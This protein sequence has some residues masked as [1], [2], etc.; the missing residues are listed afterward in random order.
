MCTKWEKRKKKPTNDKAFVKAFILFGFWDVETIGNDL[1]SL[2]ADARMM[3]SKGKERKWWRMSIRFCEHGH[4][5]SHNFYFFSFFSFFFSTLPS[6]VS[7]V[8]FILFHFFSSS[9]NHFLVIRSK[10]K[11]SIGFLHLRS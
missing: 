6:L 4:Y 2:A 8:C 9:W 3:V 5:H 1:N 7:F 10:K 11:T